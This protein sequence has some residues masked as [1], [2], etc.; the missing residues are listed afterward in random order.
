MQMEFDGFWGPGDG[1]WSDTGSETVIFA[2]CDSGIREYS[3]NLYTA[4]IGTCTV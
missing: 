1:C 4:K 3:E 2:V